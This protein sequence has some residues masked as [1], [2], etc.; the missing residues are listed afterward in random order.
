[1]KKEDIRKNI[2][3]R[4]RTIRHKVGMIKCAT[5]T[6]AGFA[7]LLNETEPTDL[8]FEAQSI[9]QYERGEVA[10]PA[11]KYEKIL[12]LDESK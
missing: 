5:I 3:W 12:S 7:K 4:I 6:Q 2:G 1:M 8:Y 10:I 9:G 11:D